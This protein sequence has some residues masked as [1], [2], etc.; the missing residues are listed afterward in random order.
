[1]QAPRLTR[2]HLKTI[3]Q[4]LEPRFN[5]IALVVSEL[6]SNSVRHTSVEGDV[7]VSVEVEADKVRLEVTDSGPCFGRDNP[8]GEGMGLNI[9]ESLSDRWGIVSNGGCTV[10]AELSTTEWAGKR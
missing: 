10:W 9:V 2:T 3:R 8:R 4:V 5:D 6:V 1:M 7:R